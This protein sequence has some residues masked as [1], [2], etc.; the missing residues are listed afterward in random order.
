MF[1][2]PAPR[3]PAAGEADDK[4]TDGALIVWK[5]AAETGFVPVAVAVIPRLILLNGV[6]AILI[7]SPDAA[8]ELMSAVI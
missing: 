2:V 5:F 7:E 4:A 6:P 8:D 1:V 3:L